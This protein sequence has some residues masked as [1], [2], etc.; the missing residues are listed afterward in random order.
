MSRDQKIKIAMVICAVIVLCAV[1]ITSTGWFSS[2]GIGGYANAEKY[3][4]GATELKEGIKNLNVNWTSGKV[5]IAYHAENTVA[6]QETA[7]RSLSED[8]QM[9]WWLDGDTLRVQYAKAGIRW[10]MPEKTLTITLPE[11][12]ELDKAGIQTT[13]GDME[14]PSL[15]AEKLELG[16]TSGS[17]DA[18]AEAEKIAAASTSGDVKI[19]LTSD[20]DSIS[21]GS[22]SGS[23]SLEAGT[24]KSISAGSTSGGISITVKECKDVSAG[25]TSGNIQ[26]S[27]GSFEKLAAG[28]TSGSITAKLPG[29]PGFTVKVDQTSGSFSSDLAL[30]KNGNTYT[31]GDGSAKAEIGTTSGSIRIE[32]AEAK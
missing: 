3:T 8:E 4:A 10:N 27:L 26:V 11:G 29:E 13:S 21:L 7:K 20:A 5:I 6:L 9:H 19:R 14:I 22:T 30:T 16:S 2:S 18:A 17:I 1:I 31:C 12:M 23:L 25:S 32:A 24:L 28:A 15:K